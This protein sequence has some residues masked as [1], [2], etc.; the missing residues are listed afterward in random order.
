MRTLDKLTPTL[1]F[2]V[3]LAVLCLIGLS[4]ELK[5]LWVVLWGAAASFISKDCADTAAWL[6]GLGKKPPIH[7]VPLSDCLVATSKE[8][9]FEDG[10]WTFLMHGN[11][12][13]APGR[14]L[15]VPLPIE[16][17]GVKS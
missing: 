1:V 12:H 10:T 7:N 17:K 2:I 16:G 6:L 11:W 5:P 8:A 3:V 9:D 15:I 14:Y 4:L 13:V